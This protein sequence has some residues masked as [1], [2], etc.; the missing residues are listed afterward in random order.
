MKPETGVFL[1]ALFDAKPSDL[2]TLLWTLPDK[3][4]TWFR[5]VADATKYAESMSDRD[6]YVGVGLSPEDFG[7]S[8]RCVS[9]RIAGLVGLWLDIDL[10]SEAHPKAALP[11]T[12]SEAL[13]I[14]P[15][16][17]PPSLVVQTGNG[18]HIWWLFRE[19]LIFASDADRQA[20]A[21]LSAS[22]Q[23]Q[24]RLIAASHGWALDP[25]PDL[26]R[27]LRVPGT[28][29]CK[30]PDHPKPVTILSQTDRR[31]SPSE[32]EEVL[33][34]YGIPE[35]EIPGEAPL[36]KP[37][38]ATGLVLDPHA[39][40]P[41]ERLSVLMQ[42]DRRFQET[43]N[44][45]RPDLKDQSQSGYDMAI[46]A[47]G[48][49]EDLPPQQIV[50]LIVHHRRMH[51]QSPRSRVEYFERTLARAARVSDGSGHT[52]VQEPTAPCSAS[53][54][55][56][57]RPPSP[58][59]D[60][61]TARALLCERLSATLGVRIMR[62][63][64]ITGKEPSYHLQLESSR[65]EFKSTAKLVTQ[66]TFRMAIAG[67]VDR[68]IP[69]FSPKTWEAMAQMILDALTIA[70]GGEETELA[71]AANLFVSQYLSETGFIDSIE[72]QPMQALR[73]PTVIDGQIAICAS[74][75]QPYVNKTFS[76]NFP[77]NAIASMLAA[78]DANNVRVRGR[79]FREQSRWL[80]PVAL[81][82]PT[83]YLPA[84]TEDCNARS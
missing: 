26:A 37:C 39:I 17:L 40:V 50:D 4:S 58:A 76:Q 27:V 64:K 15:A 80:L 7:P 79:K 25:L 19:P 42:R 81:F 83:E 32:L 10:K 8:R 62:I 63:V 21:G 14:L 55:S 12:I 34:A 67:A 73:K 36:L 35:S 78:L 30:D 24:F 41:E 66:G 29:N 53:A 84:A 51:G 2:H 6:V 49:R 70:D 59:P 54:A 20:T 82:D 77:V 43:W 56:P 31:Y 47:F 9:E 38:A 57:E 1:K 72:G 22:W 69:R 16:D 68:L 45:Q 52:G 61:A 65:I 60:P 75:L 48:F 74:D 71:G 23:R 5:S 3:H 44:R 28:T 18:L 33:A 11:S 46:A 13:S